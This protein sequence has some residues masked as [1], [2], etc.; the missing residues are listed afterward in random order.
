[1]ATTQ[2]KLTAQEVKKIPAGEKRTDTD[3]LQIGRNKSGSQQRAISPN[4]WL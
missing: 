4:F 2:T 1:M 3:G